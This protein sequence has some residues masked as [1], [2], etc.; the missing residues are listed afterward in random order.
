MNQNTLAELVSKS[1]ITSV[2][3]T[4]FRAL[5]EQNFDTQYFAAILRRTQ[6]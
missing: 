3:N 6:K 4:Y 5:D 1:E 2:V